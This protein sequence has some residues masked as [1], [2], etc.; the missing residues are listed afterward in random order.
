MF[1]DDE[2]VSDPRV[3]ASLVPLAYED[4]V[5]TDYL[6]GTEVQDAL[7]GALQRLSATR[8]RVLGTLLTQ[9]DQRKG[10]AYGGYGN[11]SYGAEPR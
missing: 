10:E 9:F 7:Q 11:Y 5:F 2:Q 3:L 1:R 4:E 8:A 6:G